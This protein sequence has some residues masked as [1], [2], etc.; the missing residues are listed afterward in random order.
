M[1][2]RHSG[3]SI[4]K[5]KKQVG[6]EKKRCRGKCDDETCSEN[7]K[8]IIVMFFFYHQKATKLEKR[9]CHE[10]QTWRGRQ[11]RRRSICALHWSSADKCD[12]QWLCTGAS[13]HPWLHI[14]LHGFCLVQDAEGS[15]EK[16]DGGARAER[17]GGGPSR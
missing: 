3:S 16:M 5:K 8:I 17:A 10:S 4:R 12:T 15:A 11:R 2:G 1:A 7:N 6:G 14:F 9:S 13:V